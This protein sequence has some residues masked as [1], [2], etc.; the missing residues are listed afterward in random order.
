MY[1]YIKHNMYLLL[2]TYIA[3]FYK[4][5]LKESLQIQWSCYSAAIHNSSNCGDYM[6]SVSNISCC[7]CYY[8]K[9]EAAQKGSLTFSFVLL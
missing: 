3:V 6:M 8:V 1:T 9:A 4:L 2:C 7:S 5:Y